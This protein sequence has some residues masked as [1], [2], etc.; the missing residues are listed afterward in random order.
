[1]NMYAGPLPLID[2][3]ISTNFSSSTYIALPNAFRSF[4]IELR[5]Q[6][7][8]DGSQ[9]FWLLCENEYS[10]NR[11]GRRDKNY[12]L[13]IEFC[14]SNA[15]LVTGYSVFLIYLPI[16]SYPDRSYLEY[17]AYFVCVVNV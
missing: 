3:D 9:H 1:M 17:S 11:K 4:E 12:Y 8:K 10:N 2:V 14:K 16:R 15:A 6:V 5:S 13:V 7:V